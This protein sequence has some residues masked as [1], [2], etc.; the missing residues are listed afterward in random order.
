MGLFGRK[1][2]FWDDEEESLVDDP[3]YEADMDDSDELEEEYDDGRW[4]PTQCA[5]LKVLARLLLFVSAVVMV[6]SGCFVYN[7]FNNGGS[8]TSKPDYYHSTNFGKEYNRNMEQLIQLVKA[9]ETSGAGQ[10]SQKEPLTEETQEAGAKPTEAQ[11]EEKAEE[12]VEKKET[13]NDYQALIKNY[14]DVGGNFSFVVYDKEGNKVIT[15]GD[16]AVDRIEASYYFVKLDSST[17]KFTSQV[18]TDN[19]GFD[20]EMWEKELMSCAND[21]VIYAGVDNS[22]TSMT[23][24]FYASYLEFN[25]YVS[26]FDIA[27]IAFIAALVIFILLLIFC[28]AATGNVKGYPGIYL[29]WFDRIFTDIA[30]L[31]IIGLGGGCA[32]AIRYLYVQ[33]EAAPYTMVLI[34]GIGIVMYIILIR[35]YFGFVRRIKAGRF[36]E[37]MVFYRI[38]E[39]FDRLPTVGMVLSMIVFLLAVNAGLVV[40]LFKLDAY[41]MFGIPFVYILVPVVF[42]LE[43][44][45]FIAWVI[46]RGAEDYDEEDED[47]YAD[48]E[49]DE[50]TEAEEETEEDTQPGLDIEAGAQETSESEWEG[51]VPDE[52]MNIGVNDDT[53][54]AVGPVPTGADANTVMLPNDEIESILAHT[55]AL[56]DSATSFDFIQL[57]KDIRKV[58]RAILKENGITVT[59][60][61]PDK[62]IIVEMNKEDMWKAISMI[63]DNLEQY[64]EKDSR[65]YA[66]MY[67]QND[68]LIYIV[69]NAVKP[70][71]VD[72]AKAAVSADANL[73]GGL[74]IAREIIEK[75]KGKFVVAFDGNIFKTGIMISTTRE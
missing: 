30:A 4:H 51:Y 25:K 5:P 23:D 60:R 73:T 28:I 59:L 42:I 52:D 1:K 69:K 44:I 75:N 2:D 55:A 31:I 14:L 50:G 12:K 26:L 35:G 41:K 71:C 67:T 13:T 20:K 40:A 61:T 53:L 45:C 18:G 17:G 49:E 33:F 47:V 27:K 19:P 22:L 66:E 15:S 68:N 9:V 56:H 57:N 24:S 37:N 8:M 43:T 11:T 63:Y 29:T 36:I 70:E 72:A 46:H 10:K 21:Y 64:T 74:K 62:P 65:V 7:Y 3:E 34:A 39:A 32:Y 6:V 16:D 58:H 54:V 38:F 48:A